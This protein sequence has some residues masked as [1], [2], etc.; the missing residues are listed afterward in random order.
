[1]I[2]YEIADCTYTV[3]Q[4]TDQELGVLAIHEI[5]RPIDEHKKVDALAAIQRVRETTLPPRMPAAVRPMF[6]QSIH[7]RVSQTHRFLM[8]CPELLTFANLMPESTKT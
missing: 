1:M 5:R 2:V 4:R 6:A 3:G 7:V 8:K